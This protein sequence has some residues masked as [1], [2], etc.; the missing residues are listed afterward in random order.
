MR[1]FPMSATKHFCNKPLPKYLDPKQTYCL[2]P[3]ALFGSGFA[4]DILP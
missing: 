3:V 1:S 2:H 4:Y